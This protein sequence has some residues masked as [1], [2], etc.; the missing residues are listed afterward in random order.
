MW[1]KNS[2]THICGGSITL[3]H[4]FQQKMRKH[5]SKRKHPYF[6]SFPTFPSS[7]IQKQKVEVT[8]PIVKRTMLWNNST[9]SCFFLKQTLYAIFQFPYVIKIYLK[10]LILK[11]DYNRDSRLAHRQILIP[12]CSPMTKSWF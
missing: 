11:F 5:N 8:R 4:F 9:M 2:F 12:N 10:K 7:E 1:N 3:P 6:F